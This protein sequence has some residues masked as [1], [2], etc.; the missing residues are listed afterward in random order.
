LPEE[1]LI[2][3]ACLVGVDCRLDGGHNSRVTVHLDRRFRLVPVCPEQLG[4]LSTPRSA[5]EIQ[6]GAGDEVLDGLARVVTKGGE[7]VTARFVAGAEETVRIAQLVGAG[8]A[9]LKARSPSCGVGRTYDGSF[10]HRL[11]DGHGVTAARLLRVGVEI[12]TEEDLGDWA[13]PGIGG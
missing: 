2:V 13:G 3:S 12:R 10:C 6:G 4:G 1:P 9:V 7:D 5:A 11:R 8:R